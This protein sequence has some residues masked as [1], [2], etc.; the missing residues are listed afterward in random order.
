MP[1]SVTDE[2][3]PYAA[4]NERRLR[5][6]SFDPA[7]AA[8]YDLAGMSGV[9]IEIPWEGNLEQGPIGEYVEVVDIDP[10]SNAAYPPVNLNA[11]A[12][13]AIEG[14]KPSESDPRF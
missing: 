1:D 12:L 10:G 6:F 13:L 14:L 7:L 4:P 5:I 2:S 9:T 3:R 11:P 8:R